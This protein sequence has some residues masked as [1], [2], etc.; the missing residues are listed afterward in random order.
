MRRF[1]GGKT[2]NACVRTRG[3]T[4][5]LSE[6]F[7]FFQATRTEAFVFFLASRAEI[8]KAHPFRADET[9]GSISLYGERMEGWTQGS[10]AEFGE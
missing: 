2:G 10:I 5:E 9:T 1:S 8:K 6:V 4:R 7:Q 3:G